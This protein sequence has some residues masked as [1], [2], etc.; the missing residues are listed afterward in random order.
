MTPPCAR[1]VASFAVLLVAAV[2]GC[3]RGGSQRDVKTYPVSGKV[4]Y[5]GTPV[6]DATVTFVGSEGHS[7]VGKTDADG[8]YH[9]MTFQPGDG[10]VPGEYQVTVVKREQTGPPP[11]EESDEDDEA[12][13][14]PPK[15]LLPEKYASR[16]TSGLKATVKK[17]S[18]TNVDFALTD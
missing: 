3:G 1:F 13:V 11:S 12:I 14:P 15:S 6:A 8:V 10:A 18:N 16:D 4:T 2:A 9:L 7:A 17:G 5:N